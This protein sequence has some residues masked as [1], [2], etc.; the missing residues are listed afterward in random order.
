MGPTVRQLS[1]ISAV[2][3]LPQL[4]IQFKQ[5]TLSLPEIQCWPTMAD[6]A[7]LAI[8]AGRQSM[9]KYSGNQAA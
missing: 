2:N 7:T 5:R 1:H 6:Y 9:I 4:T 3:R 8:L